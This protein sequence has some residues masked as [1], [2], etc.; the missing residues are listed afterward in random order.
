M[1]GRLSPSISEMSLFFGGD[2]GNGANGQKK[3]FFLGENEWP[4]EN[5]MT[6]YDRVD[7]LLQTDI[8]YYMCGVMAYMEWSGV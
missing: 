8:Y 7:V 4:K 2:G 1:D 3:C 6:C 5:C